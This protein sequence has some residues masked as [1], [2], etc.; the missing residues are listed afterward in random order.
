MRRVAD[1]S[2]W[3]GHV[4]D[5]QQLPHVLSAGIVAIVDLAGN[6]APS[7]IPRDLVYCRFPL[8]DGAGNP[9]GLLQAAVGTV[10]CLLRSETP[11]LIYCGTGMSRSPAVAGAAI[12]VVRGCSPEEGLSVATRS[13]A[14]DVSP[15]LW[16]E[17][18]AAIA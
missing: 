12:A 18:R 9:R 7:L 15:A 8:V 10:A 2:L 13:G 14:A 6:E 11:T 16:S 5:V 4:G 1:Y 17:L 3:L